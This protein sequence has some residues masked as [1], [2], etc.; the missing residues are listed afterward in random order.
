MENDSH[1]VM[2][3]SRNSVKKPQ[4]LIEKFKYDLRQFL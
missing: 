1:D 3:L 4:F 2:L